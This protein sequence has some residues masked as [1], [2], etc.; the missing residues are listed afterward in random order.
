[1]DQEQQIFTEYLSDAMANAPSLIQITMRDH[2]VAF[3]KTVFGEPM[4]NQKP[5]VSS[6][7]MEEL[8]KL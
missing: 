2:T 1:M 3:P 7:I 4:Y 6:A 8:L 5:Y